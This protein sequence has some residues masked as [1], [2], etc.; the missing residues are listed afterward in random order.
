MKGKV[1][2]SPQVVSPEEQGFLLFGAGVLGRVGAYQDF[3][4]LKKVEMRLQQWWT[5]TSTDNFCHFLLDV[6]AINLT[7]TTVTCPGPIV[8]QPG[9]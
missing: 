4:G 2:L 6:K 9:K 3:F 5:D 1:D 8:D 7:K